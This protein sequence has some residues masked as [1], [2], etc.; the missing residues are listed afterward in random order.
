MAVR[1]GENG[2]NAV[3]RARLHSVEQSLGPLDRTRDIYSRW[4]PSVT[5][6][7]SYS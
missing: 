7:L 5:M 2:D 4:D 6:Y 3:V 1:V